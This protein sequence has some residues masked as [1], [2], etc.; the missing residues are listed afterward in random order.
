M[1]KCLK[2]ITQLTYCKSLTSCLK[3]MT[4]ILGLCSIFRND[5]VCVLFLL[6][7][8]VSIYIIFNSC[9]F[10]WEPHTKSHAFCCCCP[11]QLRLDLV[12]IWAL[13]LQLQLQTAL[14]T[15]PKGTLLSRVPLHLWSP[16]WRRKL[17]MKLPSPTRPRWSPFESRLTT[18]LHPPDVS[19]CLPLTDEILLSYE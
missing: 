17:M 16:P 12:V 10:C 15:N 7:H 11:L 3:D 2:N 1:K 19:C 8:I 9:Y 6:I 14:R 4:Q 18:F 5:S 13:R